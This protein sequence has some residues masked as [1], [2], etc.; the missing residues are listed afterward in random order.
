MPIAL[1]RVL[2]CSLILVAPAALTAC[3]DEPSVELSAAGKIGEQVAEANNCMSCHSPDGPELTGPT[4]KGLYGSTVTL[5]DGSKVKVDDAYIERAL[6]EPN[7]ERRKDATGQ[8]PT[9]DEGRID[10]AELDDLIAYLQD[11]AT[12]AK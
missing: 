6:R 9:F 11:L 7:V 3:N 2:V 4:W 5:S 1:R 10:D 12:P 8:M